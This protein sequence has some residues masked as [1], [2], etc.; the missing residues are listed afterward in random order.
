MMYSGGKSLLA[1]QIGAE[2]MAAAGGC[3]VYLEPFVGGASVLEVVAP[4]FEQALASDMSEDLILMWQALQLGWNPPLTFD[5]AD[6]QDLKNSEPS[7]LRGLVGFGVSFGGLWFSSYAKNS[8]DN[9]GKGRVNDYYKQARECVLRQ[10]ARFATVTFSRRDYRTWHPGKGW[11]VYCDPPYA[12][13]AGYDAVGP[14]DSNEFWT[15][16]EKWSRAGAVV[17]VSEYMAPI[18]WQSVWEKERTS[19]LKDDTLKRIEHLFRLIEK[20]ESD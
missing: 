17:L 14:F 3:S 15:V 11:L 2:I 5:G 8:Y 10:A 13:T 4:S 9:R 7:P 1:K 20:P 18:A 16:A 19:R 6:Y 12:D